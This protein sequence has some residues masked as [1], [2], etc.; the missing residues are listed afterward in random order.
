MVWPSLVIVVLA[1]VVVI[2]VVA[3]AVV[4]V[5]A[6]VVVVLAAAFV[7]LAAAVLIVVR[8]YSRR[9]LL[10]PSSLLL[11]WLLLL[12]CPRSCCPLIIAVLC[13]HCC[14]TPV[15]HFPCRRSLRGTLCQ[16]QIRSLFAVALP[17]WSPMPGSSCSRCRGCRR[18]S[19]CGGRYA[20]G[21]CWVGFKVVSGGRGKGTERKRPQHL[22]W[23]ILAMYWHRRALFLLFIFPF[24]IVVAA[25][26]H[27][28]TTF[29]FLAR[30]L[31]H[32][33]SMSPPTS[34]LK[35]EGRV[36]LGQ[37]CTHWGVGG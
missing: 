23:T 14:P 2:V 17:R 7:V 30:Q 12:T 37:L 31:F 25:P 8:C 5:V 28:L 19:R 33:A 32:Q 22:L 6:A 4:I 35:G 13:C 11:S 20:G 10:S 3:P 27:P 21:G 18:V 26:H 9:P 34:L 16:H 29:T 36:R 1:A 15:L 24:S